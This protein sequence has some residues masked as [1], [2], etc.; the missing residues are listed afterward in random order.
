MPSEP[1]RGW[2]KEAVA[3]RAALV[4]VLLPGLGACG[5]GGGYSAPSPLPSATPATI[6][7]PLR[8]DAAAAGK[9]IGAAIQSGYL[10]EEAYSR[11][12]ARHFDYLTAEY[13]MK[14]DPVERTPGVYYFA[15]ADAIVA[16]AEQNRM[17]VKGHA[18]VWH[19]ALPDWVKALSP[20]RA[21]GRVEDHIRTVVGPLPRA[22]R[23]RGTW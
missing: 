8:A 22:H 14:W 7:D 4:L 15:G 3:R 11:T 9:W 1:T 10:N 13:E 18:L 2:Y 19:G 16:Y 17:R 23:G 20:Q 12:L 6:P 21:S 5:S